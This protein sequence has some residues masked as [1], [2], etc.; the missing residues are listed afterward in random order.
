MTSDAQ[1]H[2]R[3][4]GRL[5]AVDGRSLAALRMALGGF[6]LADLAGRWSD[7]LAFQSDGGMVS[8]ALVREWQPDTWSLYYLS[9]APGFAGLLFAL[10]ALAAGLLI[11]GY[12]TRL[13][14]G[15]SWLLLASLHNRTPMVCN[16]G[17]QL[18]R[19][20]FFWSLFL[21]LGQF[22]SVD[23][24]RLGH[25]T[26]ACAVSNIAS[27]ALLMQVTIMYFVTG[28]LKLNE[29]WFDGSGVA[30]ALSVEWYRR[31]FGDWLFRFPR[32]LTATS[33]YTLVLELVGPLLLW[34]PWRTHCWRLAMFV[35]FVLLHVGI[36]ACMTTCLFSF[37]AIASWLPF[38]PREFWESRLVRRWLPAA[39]EPHSTTPAAIPR[40]W[41]YW[42]GQAVCGLALAYVFWTNV[43]SLYEP[44]Q[45]QRW[46]Q[47]VG[48]ASTLGQRWDMFDRPWRGNLWYVGRGRL[49][50]GRI[51]DLLSADQAV[52][53]GKPPQLVRRL[54]NFRW[55]YFFCRLA[56]PEYEPLR[57]PVAEF[58]GHRWNS[59]HP[60]DKQIVVLELVLW[61]EWTLPGPH[62]GETRSSVLARVEWG[63]PEDTSNLAELL[64]ALDR[65]ES[66]LP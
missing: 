63:E 53:P 50:N 29:Q 5:A 17:D 54:P 35:A 14:T 33:W 60:P 41:P 48:S 64:R 6:V 20:L 12:R 38:L 55:R 32:L 43:A 24:R 3:G 10:A 2:G 44:W 22:A 23:R 52:P 19:M 31:P 15:V 40:P 59:N 1:G 7:I 36:E 13:M 11:V 47:W 37:V 58:L 30:G 25:P 65:G 4:F 18:L 66:P 16:A 28:L 34:I 61:D 45:S 42:G 9:G 46:N 26:R 27:F 21:P 57:Q 56:Q 39:A 51:V 62:R 8:R 49:K